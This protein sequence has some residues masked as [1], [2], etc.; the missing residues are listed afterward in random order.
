MVT[1]VLVP[2]TTLAAADGVTAKSADTITG[3][4]VVAV[5]FAGVASESAPPATTVTP[6]VPVAPGS[7]P[8]CT[9]SAG[10]VAP[11]ASPAAREHDTV[12]AASLHTQ[13]VPVAERN[14]APAG[15]VSMAVMAPVEATPP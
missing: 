13:P 10:A 3:D 15:S 7:I 12:P 2:A 6:V 4:E 1:V 9:L 14:T 5:L 8:N 11:A